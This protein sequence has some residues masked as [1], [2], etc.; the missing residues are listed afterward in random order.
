M[1]EWHLT[2]NGIIASTSAHYSLQSENG[3]PSDSMAV[4]YLEKWMSMNNK[5]IR[6][7][8]DRITVDISLSDGKVSGHIAIGS[9]SLQLERI[10]NATMDKFMPLIQKL[11]GERLYAECEIIEILEQNYILILPLFRLEQWIDKIFI[12]QLNAF[13][14]E[15]DKN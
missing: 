2:E 15:L 7:L 10:A 9:E 4:I 14:L 13:Q 3:F 8:G 12:E 6:I 1:Q 5:Y 11:F